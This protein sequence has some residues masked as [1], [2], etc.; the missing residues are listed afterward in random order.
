M[1]LTNKQIKS[2]VDALNQLKSFITETFSDLIEKA[3]YLDSKLAI[4]FI[5]QELS[6]KIREY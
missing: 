2:K 3:S 4:K 6:K 1:N 5:K